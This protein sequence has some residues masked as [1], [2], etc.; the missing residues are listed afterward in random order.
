MQ[1]K[2]EREIAQQMRQDCAQSILKIFGLDDKCGSKFMHLPF[3]ARGN[4]KIATMWRYR[5]GLHGT[6]FPNKLLRFSLVLPCIKTGVNFGLSAYVS[7]LYRLAEMDQL[8]KSLYRQTDSGPDCDAKETHALH[9]LLVFIGLISIHR[10]FRVFLGHTHSTS[11]TLVSNPPP[12]QPPTH[13]LPP[14]HPPPQAW[15]T[16]LSGSA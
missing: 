3:F 1:I 4:A 10:A 8:G 13:L 16:T 2:E 7:A 14:T 5:F 15:S 12:T 6:I 11:P 9:S